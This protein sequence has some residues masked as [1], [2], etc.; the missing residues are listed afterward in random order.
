MTGLY[1]YHLDEVDT[2]SI[3]CDSSISTGGSWG[4][5]LSSDL[6]F[7]GVHEFPLITNPE[8][9]KDLFNRFQHGQ[10]DGILHIAIEGYDEKFEIDDYSSYAKISFDSV[11]EDQSMIEVKGIEI[12]TAFLKLTKKDTNEKIIITTEKA[13]YVDDSPG[14]PSN[15]RII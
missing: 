11:Y 4:I 3:T 13:E 6:I 2:G 10:H 1:C 15:L 14:V 5:T 8:E 9:R 7:G 12:K